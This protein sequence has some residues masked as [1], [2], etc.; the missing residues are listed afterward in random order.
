MRPA[1]LAA[2]GVLCAVAA[3]PLWLQPN[4]SAPSHH[5]EHASGSQTA[6]PPYSR[7]AERPPPTRP[8]PVQ[9]LVRWIK[10]SRDNGRLPFFVVD[11]IDARVIA[12]TPDATYLASAPALLGSARGDDNAPDI[13]RKPLSAIQPGERTTAAGRFVAE[14]GHN[15]HGEE[16]LWVDYDAALSM[17]RVRALDPAERRLERLA[18]PESSD[19]RISYGC[20]NVPVDFF[21]RRVLPLARMSR[22]LVYVVPEQ[23]PLETV[24]D[25]DGKK[26]LATGMR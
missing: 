14:L 24:F 12:Y 21:E 3:V 26:R 15:N 7:N 11:K 9:R 6:V 17:H 20:I 5:P 16:V 13:G 19:N 4:D 23:R 2:G 8:P 1:A 22:V 18:S 25:I 10:T